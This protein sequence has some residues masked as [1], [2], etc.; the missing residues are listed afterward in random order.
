MNV[1]NFA[2]MNFRGFMEIG[3]FA[4]IKIRVLGSTGSLGFYK[5]NFQGV[6]IFRGYLRIANY[7]EKCTT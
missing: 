6:H 3:N 4:C 5:C 7:A 1:D 2:C